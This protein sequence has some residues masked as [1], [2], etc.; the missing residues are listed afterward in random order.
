[1]LESAIRLCS[2]LIISLRQKILALADKFPPLQQKWVS[3]PAAAATTSARRPRNR[4]RVL[5]VN[6]HRRGTPG[7]VRANLLI[8]F[9]N[10]ADNRGPD[11]DPTPNEFPHATSKHCGHLSWGSASVL[12]RRPTRRRHSERRALPTRRGELPAADCRPPTSHWSDRTT[13]SGHAGCESPRSG[14]SSRP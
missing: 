7:C 8:W 11:R 5:D 6:K 9:V 2:V 14:S 4:G 12:I 10:L 1:M 13:G 3:C